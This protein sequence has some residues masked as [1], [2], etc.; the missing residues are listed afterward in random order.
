VEGKHLENFNVWIRWAASLNCF[1]RSDH[2]RTYANLKW[3]EV[4]FAVVACYLQHGTVSLLC[5]SD[6]RLLPPSYALGYAVS[7]APIL[8]QISKSC[9]GQVTK[10]ALMSSTKCAV[11]Y[12]NSAAHEANNIHMPGCHVDIKFVLPPIEKDPKIQADFAVSVVSSEGRA[13]FA[14][15]TSRQ[16][17]FQTF[18]LRSSPVLHVVACT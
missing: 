11:I 10:S 4:I 15:S 9:A 14:I 13:G 7:P 5:V 1:A 16:N 2:D 12:V 17:E 6:S 18:P 3:A 8:Q